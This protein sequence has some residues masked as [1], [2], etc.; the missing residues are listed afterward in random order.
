MGFHHGYAVLLDDLADGEGDP[1]AV[2]AQDELDAVLGDQL[3]DQP[4]RRRGIRLVVVVLDL[5]AVLGPRHLDAAELLVDVLRVKIV[6]VLH[7]ASVVGQAPRERQRRAEADDPVL[8]ERR[9]SEA[10]QGDDAD[11][12]CGGEAGVCPESNV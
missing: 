12:E 7:E 11:H 3:L 6:P 4:R 10:G 1:A 5:D 9:R 2:W 8:G